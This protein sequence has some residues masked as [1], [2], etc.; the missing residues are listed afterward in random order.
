M[1]KLMGYFSSLLVAYSNRNRQTLWEACRHL[2]NHV[3]GNSSLLLNS[4]H[5]SIVI[6]DQ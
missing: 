6:E 3:N 4:L 5:T 2:L 1:L